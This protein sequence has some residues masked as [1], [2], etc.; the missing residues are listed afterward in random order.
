MNPARQAIRSTRAAC[1]ALFQTVFPDQCWITGTPLSA[2]SPHLSP[3]I[4]E[5]IARESLTNY[6]RRCGSTVGPYER[7]DRHSPCL[8]CPT[9][10][11][12]VHTLA[13]VGHF[14]PPLSRLVYQ[15][16]FAGRWELAAVAAPFLFQALTAV[17]E[18]QQMPIDTL[19]PLP[20]HWRR[21]LKRTFNQ[22]EELACHLS[23]L[24]SWPVRQPLRRVKS[25]A[26]QSGIHSK[27][28]RRENMKGAFICRP[29]PWLSG[30]HLWL[31]DDV[32]TTG[33]TLHAAAT[34]I[35]KLA[36]AI[37]PASINALVL[38]VTDHH[39]TPHVEELDADS[40]PDDHPVTSIRDC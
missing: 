30:K 36:P 25:T 8:R 11:I 1:A 14:A 9:R 38:C 21:R 2:D 39:G 24:G 19:I 17:S 22:S 12:G 10:D 6:C 3:E 13:R 27:T 33:A 26:E 29:D 37:R 20:L 31:L 7:H 15:I 23:A 35:R 40:V 5:Q 32:C 4:R 16:K 34:A 18:Q 28:Q